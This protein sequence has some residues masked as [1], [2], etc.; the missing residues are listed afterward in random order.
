VSLRFPIPVNPTNSNPWI[1]VMSRTLDFEPK[2]SRSACSVQQFETSERREEEKS[3]RYTTVRRFSVAAR[4][5][6]PTL[7]RRTTVRSPSGIV[8]VEAPFPPLYPLSILSRPSRASLQ[9]Q[10]IAILEPRLPSKLN[11]HP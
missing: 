10:K 2:N 1:K 7:R 5:D 8:G 6:S 4:F 11:L 9:G 3:R